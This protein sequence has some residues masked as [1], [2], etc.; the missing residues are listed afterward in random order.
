MCWRSTMP[1]LCGG[2]HERIEFALL[3]RVQRQYQMLRGGRT[4]LIA[5]TLWQRAFS[6]YKKFNTQ[7]G[8][9]LRYPGGIFQVML[10]NV[11]K[12]FWRSGSCPTTLS[13]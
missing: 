4:S 12:K 2:A 1:S 13:Q 10:A 7:P 6:C 9:I 11:G 3:R 8:R 5:K